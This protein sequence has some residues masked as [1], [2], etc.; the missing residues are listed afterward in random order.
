M[1]SQPDNEL[2]SGIYA[3]A[4]SQAAWLPVLDRIRA[5]LDVES[6][7]V[8]RL[9]QQG[10]RLKELWTARDAWSRH[11]AA[12][13]DQW[14]NNADNPRFRLRPAMEPAPIG[15]DQRFFAGEPR[16]LGQLNEGLS[17]IG[18][19]HAIW[20]GFPLPDRQHFSL[21][22][23]RKAGDF[24][25]LSAHE[26]AFLQTLLPH[27]KQ[28][29]SL[30]DRIDRTTARTRQLQSAIDG[31]GAA[32]L[33][34]DVDQQVE[35]ANPRASEIVDRS[36]HLSLR[37][38]QLRC[39]NA[40]DKSRLRAAFE[41][42]A[43]SGQPSAVVA[44]GGVGDRPLHLRVTPI[45]SANDP[46]SCA[47]GFAVSLTEPEQAGVLDAGELAALFGLTAA[48]SR[49]AA[50]IA[51][52]LSLAEFAEG[53]GIALGTARFQLRQVLAKTGARRQAELVQQLWASSAR[54]GRG[55]G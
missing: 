21:I 35:W 51:A 8:Q 18:L 5:S 16:L 47:D 24:R 34:C 44:L 22:I 2:I 39:R 43:Q 32:V 42:I 53:R 48:E 29:A 4:G 49:L 17:R 14:V 26:E 9:G 45:V 33:V 1:Q 11:H 41:A 37:D 55:D 31:V 50:A 12:A 25:D 20:A 19:G 52:G 3:T 13:H 54:I 15:S 38:G 27:F 6:A 46:R 10:A 7:V 23:H 28:A 40:G 36:P 30:A